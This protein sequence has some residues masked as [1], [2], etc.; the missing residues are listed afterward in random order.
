M[1]TIGLDIGTTSVCGVLVDAKSGETVKAYTKKNSGFIKNANDYEKIQDPESILALC[2]EMY[3]DFLGMQSDVCCVGIDGQMHGIVYLDED[4]NSCSPLYTWQD[5][6]G[7]LAYVDGKTYTQYLSEKTGYRLAA[8]YG[9]VTHFYNE[10]NSLVPQNARKF[11]TIHDYVAMKLAQKKT[12][13]VHPSDAASFGIFD[14]EKSSFDL[15]KIEKEFE[16]T[17][18]FPDVCK[19]YACVGKTKDGISVYCA[20]GDNQASVIGSMNDKKSVLVN[21][22]TG[23]QITIIRNEIASL[24]GVECRPYVEGGY[25]WVGSSLCGGR[26]FAIL[27]GFFRSVAEMITGKPSSSLYPQIDALMAKDD[28]TNCNPLKFDTSFN[29]SRDNPKKRASITDIDIDNF[30]AREMIKATLCGIAKELFDY[31][32]VMGKGR[33]I[34]VSSLVGSG[35]GVKKNE[36]LKLCFEKLFGMPLLLPSGDEQAAFG[37]CL[38][39]LVGHGVYKDIS[40]AQQLIKYE[41]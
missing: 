37:A 36:Y 2:M 22:G 34:E 24:P 35:N 31:Y 17:G 39:A 5:A 15:S 16:N 25:L 33:S 9:C 29:G 18:L 32:E 41:K 12:P 30:N 8:G 26:A 7:D 4:G 6:R 19:D 38:F 28:D 27:E 14:I 3:E 23:S 40:S 11:C 20:I 10:K 1:Y 13:L 21:V